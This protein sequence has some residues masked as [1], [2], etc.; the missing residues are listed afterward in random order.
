MVS[1]IETKIQRCKSRHTIY[2]RTGFVTDSTFPFEVGEKLV[3]KIEKGKVVI[4][5]AESRKT[6]GRS[7]H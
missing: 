7:E 3:A 6:D 4:E 5:K 2:L 1:E